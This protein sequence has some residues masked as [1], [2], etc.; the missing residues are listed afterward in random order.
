MFYGIIIRMLYLDNRQHHLP[1]LHVEYQ[2]M[3][4]VITIPDGEL[5]EGKLPAK[6]LRLVQAWI[7]I[8]EDE[9]MANWSLAVNGEPIFSIDPLR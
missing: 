7:T 2:G 3:K 9:V 4:S 5:L 1:H 6:K 8:H